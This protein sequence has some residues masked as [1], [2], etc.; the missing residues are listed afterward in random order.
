MPRIAGVNIP[1]K[2]QIK[3][4]LTY[5]FGIGLPNSTRILKQV[6]IDP[7][8][9]AKDL[10]A[11][12]LTMLRDSLEKEFTIEGDLRREVMMNIKRLR[13]IGSWRGS[14]HQKKLPARGQRTST[15]SRT[16]RGN[17]RKTVGSGKKPAASPT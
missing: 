6:K 14:R 15:N 4:A 5:I 2:K 9:K 16:I 17:V 8:K 3:I 13:D 10:S 11:E 7:Q 12:E 1:E